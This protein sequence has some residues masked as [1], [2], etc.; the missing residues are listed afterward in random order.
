MEPTLLSLTSVALPQKS[1]HPQCRRIALRFLSF[2]RR[3]AR[4]CPREKYPRREDVE[5]TAKDLGQRMKEARS[6]KKFVVDSPGN[7]DQVLEEKCD[8]LYIDILVKK[9]K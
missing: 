1:P 3:P 6:Q 4:A 9:V 2:Q 8:R 5:L 7:Y